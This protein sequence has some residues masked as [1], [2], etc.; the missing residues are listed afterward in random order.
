MKNIL[1]IVVAISILNV[2]CDK[3]QPLPAKK[4][5]PSKHE[6][7]M[8]DIQATIQNEQA[9]QS[10]YKIY[11][12]PTAENKPANIKH[13]YNP[14]DRLSTFSTQFIR[15]G[16]DEA[17][18]IFSIEGEAQTHV[19]PPAEVK[20]AFVKRSVVDF[21]FLVNGKQIR[22]RS[23]YNNTYNIATKDLLNIVQADKVLVRMNDVEFYL[24]QSEKKL[25]YDV[26][27][28]MGN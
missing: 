14:T 5:E 13:S 7:L 6:Q 1:C 3:K 23:G 27:S 12:F 24:R 21:R 19:K 17:M 11:K 18:M 4:E 26:L 16:N 15:F 10:E 20:I 8:T 2:G 25:F 9:W 22:P 28:L